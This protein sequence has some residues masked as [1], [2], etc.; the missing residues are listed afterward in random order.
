MYKI[1]ANKAVGISE[2]KQNPGAVLT[3]AE[4]EPVAILNRNKPAGYIISAAVWEALADQL[5]DL[6]LAAVANERMNDGE[7]SVRVSLDEL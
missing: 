5:E 6:A 7:Q 4:A 2:L 3:A 1:L